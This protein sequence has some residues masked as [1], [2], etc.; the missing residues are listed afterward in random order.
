MTRKDYIRAINKMTNKIGLTLLGTR[1]GKY[2]SIQYD[3]D[4]KTCI[5]IAFNRD[6]SCSTHWLNR[7]GTKTLEDIYLD[8]YVDFA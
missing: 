6:G 3:E 7:L 8:L 1:C 4:N 2:H 5:V